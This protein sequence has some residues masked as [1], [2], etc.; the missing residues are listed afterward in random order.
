M[1]ARRILILG[2][3]AD[4]RD[5]A[6]AAA[7]RFGAKLDVITSLAGRTSVPASYVGKIRVG[8][9][10]GAVGI[11]A[12]LRQE[13]IDL[14]V[15]ATHPFAARMSAQAGEAAA[16]TGVKLLALIRP[17]WAPQPG[18]RWTLVADAAA[19]AAALGRLGDRVFLSFGGR[20][21]E[22]F[23]PLTAKWFLVRRIEQPAGRLPL[24]SYEIT[25]G[26]GPFLLEQER[27]LMVRHRIDVLVTK[28]SGGAATRAK[29]DAAREL[30]LPVVMIQR[31]SQGAGV[32]VATAAEAVR[33]IAAA[34]FAE[35]GIDGAVAISA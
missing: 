17:T 14:L 29:L 1:T 13:R 3:T 5:L 30:G 31:P 32:G 28:A 10:G 27:D 16:M 24:S 4:A 20:E 22:A 35:A 25:L 34:L 12:Y 11:A 15:D 33:S 18:D 9:F 2:G 19:A 26:R 23:A 6:A 21:L 7:E 8:G